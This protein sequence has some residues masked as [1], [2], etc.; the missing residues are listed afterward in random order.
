MLK[1][2]VAFI[3][4]GTGAVGQALVRTLARHGARVAFSYHNSADKA[5]ELES[6]P[7]CAGRLKAYPLDVMDA[8]MANRLAAQV[9]QEIGP[10]DIL[11]NNSGI[12]QVLPFA[13]I[14]EQDWD[15]VMDVNVKGMFIVTKAFI[16][17]M[18]RRKTGAIVNLGSLAGMRMLEVPVHYATAKSAVAG[19]TMSLAREMAR[20]HI[21]VNAIVPG[22]LTDGVSRHVPEAQT[23]DYLQH[24]AMG[25]AGTPEEVAELAAFLASDRASYINAQSIHIDGGI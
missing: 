12:T 14:E 19:F 2:R 11:V 3:T 24:C 21:R 4:G 6:D 22:L 9:E 10:V 25:R 5:R 20:Y 8:A 7:D 15:L 16:R 23:A 1:G 17:S 18:I 13:L